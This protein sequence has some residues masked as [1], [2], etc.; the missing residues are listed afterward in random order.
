MKAVA[1]L[2]I[3]A[4]MLAAGCVWLSLCTPA[5]AGPTNRA[6]VRLGVDNAGSISYH[7]QIARQHTWQSEAWFRGLKELGV[8]FVS[9]HFSPVLNGGTNNSALTRQKL[10]L[11]DRAVRFDAHANHV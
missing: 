8:G 5:W 2:M 7:E 11:I 6:T 1:A 4:G 3:F 9:T 10:E